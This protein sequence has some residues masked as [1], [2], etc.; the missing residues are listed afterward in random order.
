[1]TYNL[2][3]ILI[4]PHIYRQWMA[5]LSSTCASLAKKYPDLQPHEIPDEMF[6]CDGENTKGEIFV[7]VRDVTVKMAVPAKYWQFS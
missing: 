2:S 3:S 7:T 1:M 5:H 4:T 6:R